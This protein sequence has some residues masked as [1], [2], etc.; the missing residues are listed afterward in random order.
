[1]RNG[2]LEKN[3]QEKHVLVTNQTRKT[4]LPHHGVTFA[5]ICIS[6]PVTNQ[7]QLVSPG[8]TTTPSSALHTKT[9]S[10]HNSNIK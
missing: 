7:N 9:S 2:E 5:K 10:K 6:S 4:K 3:Y 8:T 1:M